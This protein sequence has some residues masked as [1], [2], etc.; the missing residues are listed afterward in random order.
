MTAMSDYLEDRVIDH[1]LRAQAFTPAA[2]LYLALYS[3]ATTDAGGGTEASG[4]SYARQALTIGAPALGAASN[5]NV[6]TFP[7]MPAGTWT[8]AAI[9]DALTLGNSLFH[10][11]LTTSKTTTAGKSLVLPVGELDVSFTAGSNATDFLRNLIINRFLRNQAHTPAATLYLA[12]YTTATTRTG[13]GTEVTGGGYARQAIALV[14]A[15]GGVTSNSGVVDTVMPAA[16]ATHFAIHDALSA[17][18]MYLQ[19]PLDSSIV[20]G[21]GDIIRWA[22]GAYDLVVT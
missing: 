9:R 2:Q 4:G 5:S 15:S 6:L 18:N 3:D 17:G 16:T 7:N 10:G 21:A 11:P 12:Q 14:A 22:I 1:L 19:G 8:H 13:G 20:A